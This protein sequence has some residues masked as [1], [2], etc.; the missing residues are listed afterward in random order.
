M[1][2]LWTLACAFVTTRTGPR[3]TPTRV[4][5]ATL[6]VPLLAAGAS[7]QTAGG[8]QAL[9]SHQ[10]AHAPLAHP[11][12]AAAAAV[13]LYEDLGH[14][15][16]RVSTQ[17]TDAQRYFDQGLR[18][19]YGFGLPEARRAFR[20]AARRDSTCA[21][22]W[23][24]LAWA[25]GPYIN[26]PSL[27]SASA[28]EAY[29]AVQ[30]AVAL[31][32]RA[33]PVERALIEAMAARYATHAGDGGAASASPTRAH[34]DSAYADA[35]REVVRR[36]PDDRDAGAI[37]GEALMVLRPWNQWTRTGEPQP[38]T[39]E[40]LRTLERVLRRDLRHPGACHYYI[41]ATEASPHPER[42]AACADLL[43]RAIP[44][45]SHIPHMPSHT[46]MRMG[47]Y[48]DAVHAN[49]QARLADQR[50]RMGGAPGTYVA[51][52]A[53][54]LASAGT[55]DGQ[56]AVAL[57]AAADLGRAAP[58]VIY[59][60]RAALARFGRWRELADAPQPAGTDPLSLGMHAFARGIGQLGVGAADGARA[61]LAALDTIV[62]VVPDTL[63]LGSHPTIALLGMARGIL[64]GELFASQRRYAEAVDALRAAVTFGDS[65]M[66]DEPEPWPL[67]PRHVLGGVLLDAGRAADAEA[68]LRDDLRKHPANGWALAGLADALRA[69]GKR[70]EADAVA[71][72]LTRVWSRADVPIVGARWR[73]GT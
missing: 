55:M 43:G 4:A 30:R 32:E 73:P 3:A 48:G 21:M 18:L 5:C 54:M 6:L 19:T 51:H 41:H 10:S 37:F 24:G 49:Q 66:Y 47:R 58:R 62:A 45:A 14:Q 27:D 52:N 57:Q 69:Q 2:P 38:G 50:A 72:E 65:L 13:P 63:R 12:A 40:V 20:E 33:T 26:G 15:S 61:Q 1:F 42:A 31:R 23:W 29:T 71:A 11:P 35:M 34:L 8:T 22:C 44:G 39:E 59:Y 56:S 36:F 60:H 53:H 70:S 46:Y 68:V 16:R 17:S 25:L 64:A 9:T 67:P 28:V 7:A